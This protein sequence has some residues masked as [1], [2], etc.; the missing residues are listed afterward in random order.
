MR[1]TVLHLLVCGCF[2]TPCELLGD[3]SAQA[4]EGVR[5]APA[6]GGVEIEEIEIVR[7]TALGAV[8]EADL[9]N[10]RLKLWFPAVWKRTDNDFHYLI[11]FQSLSPI[12]DITDKLLSTERRVKEI[13]YLHGEVR[14]DE[15]MASG[16]KGG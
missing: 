3:R 16:G 1:Q 12:Q 7:R 6:S 10:M 11:R 14:G 8:K 2:F 4:D 9:I 15:W 5:I 13:E